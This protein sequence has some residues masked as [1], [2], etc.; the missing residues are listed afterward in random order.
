MLLNSS[1]LFCFSLYTVSF[2]L[3]AFMT[4]LYLGFSAIWWQH[5][6]L[7]IISWYITY[8]NLK[9]IF[10][11][12]FSPIFCSIV[13]IHLTSHGLQ[14]QYLRTIFALKGQLFKSD[15]ILNL[16]CPALQIFPEVFISLCN[17]P[18][19]LSPSYSASRLS[20]AIFIV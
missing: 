4:A 11:Q 13:V 10:A 8:N 19:F 7:Q 16:Y 20:L 18:K 9:T 5:I 15:S 3:S 14:T 17:N 6:Y 1:T 2:P 12:L